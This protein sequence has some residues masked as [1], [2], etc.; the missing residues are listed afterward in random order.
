MRYIMKIFKNMRFS[1]LKREN[2]NASDK[3]A[4][5]FK[6]VWPIFIEMTL[7]MLVGNVDQYMVTRYSENAV[8]AIGNANQIINLL[9]I[10]FN[11]ISMS[12][13]ILVA[14]YIG[15]NNKHKLSTIYTL[16]LCVNLVF[17]FIIMFIIICFSG[18]IFRFMK[19]PQDIYTDA[20]TYILWIGGFIFLQAII[21][22]FSAIFRANRMMKET[23]L[24]SVFINLVNVLGNALLINGAGFLPA[25]GVAG[26][27]IATNVSRLVGI[28]LYCYLF[29][30]HFDTRISL[31]ALSPFPR[32]ELKKLLGIGIPSGGESF[33]YSIAM[34]LILKVVNAFGTFV[35]NTKVLASTF[36]WF[37]YMYSSAVGQASQVVIG[38]YMGAGK[39]D[40]VDR[41]VKKTLRNAII[42]SLVISTTMFI[43][44]DLLFG[45]FS[46]DPRVLALGKKIM[47]IEILLELGKCTNITLVRSL[48]AT[49]DI[50]FPMIIGMVFMWAVAFGF[51]YVLAVV[52]NLGLVGI[53]IG[54]A[55]DEDIRAIIFLIRWKKGKWR[56]IRLAGD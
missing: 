55:L 5:L 9:M 29:H 8:G 10:M 31:K 16:S 43:F 49:G 15:S 51:G 23:M 36:S 35:I 37:S 45:L 33:S 18:T 24:I 44:S 6:L 25:L 52:C 19:V 12:T 48:Q 34:T 26:A 7:T 4:S 27:A 13:I 1:F 56:N 21:S 11:L 39:V 30:K 53:W 28:L 17:S 54:M 50:K 22:V 32:M 3:P 47:F 2:D 38:N 40:Q 14:Q 41:R 20:H 46:K 42:V